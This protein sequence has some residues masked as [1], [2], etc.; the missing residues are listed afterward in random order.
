[1][2]KYIGVY[3]GGEWRFYQNVGDFNLPGIIKGEM[4]KRSAK[5]IELYEITLYEITEVLCS[6]CMK[7][8]NC[9]S[10]DFSLKECGFFVRSWW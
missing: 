6:K 10:V 3:P 5:Y 2:A 9:V 1:M 7:F 8:E 4:R